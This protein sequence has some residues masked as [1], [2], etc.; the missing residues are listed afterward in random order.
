[1]NLNNILI[2]CQAFRES[3]GKDPNT[4]LVGDVTYL[5][6]KEIA[7]RLAQQMKQDV[8]DP[9]IQILGMRIIIDPEQPNRLTVSYQECFSNKR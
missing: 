3:H 5:A 1:M 4:I 8:G 7:Q 6:L 9:L 2:P